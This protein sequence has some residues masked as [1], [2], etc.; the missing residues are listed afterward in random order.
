L[1]SERVQLIHEYD[2]RR[3][4]GSLLEQSAHASRAATHE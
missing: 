1:L 2:A 4:L 3:H